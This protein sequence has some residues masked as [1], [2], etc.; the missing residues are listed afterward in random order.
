MLLNLDRC[1]YCDIFSKGTMVNTS[2]THCI[3]KFKY[4][5]HCIV[6]TYILQFKIQTALSCKPIFLV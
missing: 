6:R 1:R 4:Q 2:Y 5:M 3:T